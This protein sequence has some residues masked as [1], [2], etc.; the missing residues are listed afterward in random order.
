MQ[1]QNFK[2]TD[3]ECVELSPDESIR[4]EG[5]VIALIAIGAVVIGTLGAISA[6][7]GLYEWGYD[8][9]KRHLN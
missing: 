1:P 3:F 8:Y 2:K 9:A 4:I 7:I 6:G 5:G